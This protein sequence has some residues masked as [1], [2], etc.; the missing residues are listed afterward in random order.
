MIAGMRRSWPSPFLFRIGDASA[1]VFVVSA[2]MP[3]ENPTCQRRLQRLIVS[4]NAVRLLLQ[5]I[6]R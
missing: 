1:G 2:P 5:K 6:C 3:F 4:I